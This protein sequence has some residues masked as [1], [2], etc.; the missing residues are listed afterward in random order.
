MVSATD[1]MLA[2]VQRL[3]WVR[4]LPALVPWDAPHP[5]KICTL[6]ACRRKPLQH[7]KAQWAPW[8]GSQ[9]KEALWAARAWIGAGSVLAFALQ[10]GD[11]VPL[12][13]QWSREC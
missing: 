2:G 12:Q 8:A 5:W 6:C 7:S 9:N 11:V 4:K 10:R 3:W 13:L 1:V